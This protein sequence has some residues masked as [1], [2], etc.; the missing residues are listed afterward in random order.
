MARRVIFLLEPVIDEDNE[1]IWPKD[2]LLE[3]E[4]TFWNTVKANLIAK[5]AAVEVHVINGAHGQMFT[6]TGGVTDK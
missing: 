4:E 3:V 2:S 5:K 1:V 6:Y